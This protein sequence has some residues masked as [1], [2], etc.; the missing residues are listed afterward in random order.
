MSTNNA[1]VLTETLDEIYEGVEMTG[2]YP[3]LKDMLSSILSDC[4]CDNPVVDVQV[5][6]ET[7]IEDLEL[8][9]DKLIASVSAKMG[10]KV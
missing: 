5:Q 7:M 2:G 1:N 8:L 4:E 9:K 6:L 3:L 10:P